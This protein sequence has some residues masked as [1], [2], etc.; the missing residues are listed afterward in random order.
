MVFFSWFAFSS[1][2]V[3]FTTVISG[4]VYKNI[5]DILGQDILSINERYHLAVLFLFPMGLSMMT[6]VGIIRYGE[7]IKIRLMSRM[8]KRIYDFCFVRLNNHSYSFYSDTFAGSL[9]AKA[10]RYARAFEVAMD[11]AVHSFWLTLLIVIATSAALYFQSKT[12]ALYIVGWSIIYAALTLIFVKQKIKLDLREAEADSKLTGVLADTIT[13]ILNIKIF[14]AFQKEFH[15]FQDVTTLVKDRNIASSRFA[16]IRSGVQA[17]LMFTFHVFL[18]YTMLR[19]WQS[20]EITLGV[21]VMTYV[22]LNAIIDRIWDLSSGV[23]Q[24]MKAMTDANEM[25]EIFDTKSDIT[26]PEKPEYLFMK[27]GNVCFQDVA[28]KYQNGASVFEKLHLSIPAGQKVGIVG[29]SGAGKSTITKLLLRF[30]D[31][32]EGAI[33]IDGQDIRN[34]TQDDLRSAITYVPQ[35][36]LLFHR[37]IYENIAYGNPN[38][39]KEEVI[40]AARAASAHEFIE[41]LQDGY[42]TLVGERGVKL[43]GGERQ[44][45]AIARAMLKHAPILILDEATS[46]LDSESEAHIQKA[47]ATLI[48]GKTALVIA[49]RLSTIQKMDRILVF[50]EGEIVEDGTH[51]ELIAKNGVYANLWNHQVGGFIVE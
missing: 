28:F 7:W 51:A 31:V 46:S 42:D 33:T 26:D 44:R 20:G 38:A 25:V 4:L 8:N 13:N 18:L 43:S 48:E 34:V 17:F 35:E 36:P 27:N 12:L 49:H 30:A 41:K 5:I 2:R 16:L 24:F 15:Y 23:T 14:S 10:R 11:V 3:I 29:H 6:S 39:S 47:L 19:L 22:Y 40:A 45:V 37:S 1:G 21:F 9:V 32:T 50:E